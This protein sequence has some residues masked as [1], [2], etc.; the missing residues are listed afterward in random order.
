MQYSEK[1]FSNCESGST[2][3]SLGQVS[4]NF[5][6]FMIKNRRSHRIWAH[7]V[8]FLCVWAGADGICVYTSNEE[9][10]CIS[11]YEWYYGLIG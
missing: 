1:C 5:F 9:S 3:K 7:I 4:M 6:F 10:K 11:Y 8:V 2:K